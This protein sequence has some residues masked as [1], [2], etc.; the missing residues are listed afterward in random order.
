LSGLSEERINAIVEERFKRMQCPKCGKALWE[1]GNIHMPDR[2]MKML[3]LRI[4]RC[5][6]CGYTSEW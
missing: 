4:I 6:S 2:T 1:I 3:N 5:A